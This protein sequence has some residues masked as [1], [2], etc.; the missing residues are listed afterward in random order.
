MQRLPCSSDHLMII[1]VRNHSNRITLILLANLDHVTRQ[2]GHQVQSEKNF[3]KRNAINC[4]FHQYVNALVFKTCHVLESP[5]RPCKIPMSWLHTIAIK[6][7]SP[8][9]RSRHHYFFTAPQEI[10]CMANLKNQCVKS[11]FFFF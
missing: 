5:G 2:P 1:L 10:Q 7:K 4:S 3:L 6:S 9:V 8:G 11:I